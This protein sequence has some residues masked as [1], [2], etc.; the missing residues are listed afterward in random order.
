MKIRVFLIAAIAAVL[1]VASAT[2]QIRE[3]TVELSGFAGYL[4]GGHFGDVPATPDYNY[5][6]RLDIGDD[7]AY[8]GRLGYNF[9]N[10]FEAEFEY[11]RS[12]TNLQ[13]DPF[14]SNLPTVDFAPLT[15]QY[16]M[17]YLTFNFGRGRSVGYFTIGGG[18]ADFQ[19][20]FGDIG[21]VSK[22]YGTAAIGGGYKYFVNPHFGLRLD[23]RFYST[24][25]GSRTFYCGYGY[26]CSGTTWVTSFVPNGGVIIAF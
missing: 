3:G 1:S 5:G 14:R 7:V 6:Y 23:A 15:L 8:G 10:T 26:Y 2:A 12:P 11:S 21:S 17:G 18:A 19:A 22:T 4:V 13:V 25:V 9:N 24:A 20:H 16:F